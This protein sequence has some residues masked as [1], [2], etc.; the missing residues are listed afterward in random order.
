MRALASP[1]RRR[2][3][4]RR[5]R[6]RRRAGLAAL[7]AAAGRRGAARARSGSTQ[8]SRVLLIGSEGDTD[9]EIYRQDRRAARAEEVLRVRANAHLRIDA[10][11]LM[12]PA[13][14]LAEIGAIDG[15]GCC[16]LALT[17]EDQRGPRPGRRLDA[18][19]R[20]RGRASTASATCSACAPAREARRAGDDRLAH[21]HR[22]HR[23]AL[24]RQPRRARRARGR[25]R[26]SNAAGVV[27]RRPLVVA[28]FTNEEGARFAPDMLGSLV[29]VGRPAAG[30]GARRAVAID[31]KRA[32]RRA[33]R[34]SATPA[35]RRCPRS[36]PAR[37]RRAAHRAGPGARRRGHH[38]RRG[39]GPAGH[40][41]AGDRDHRPVQ[42]RRHHADAAAPRRRLL[43]GGDRRV[44]A[45]ARARDGRRAR[46]ARWADRRCT[47]PDQRR[48]RRA[49]R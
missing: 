34:A 20:P 22:A 27:T 2:S 32:R 16:R 44:P 30:G 46:S 38:H 6:D 37:V 28:F 18:R 8:A 5:R 40:L 43:R 15:G 45:R 33:A 47:Q 14:P 1:A 24:R 10:D 13:R 26:R 35:P 31:G 17:D 23:R 42:P 19:A 9:P 21:R 7:L 11:R 4:D 12:A 25:R 3:G 29:Y 39:R 36:S 49:R 41:V 48:S